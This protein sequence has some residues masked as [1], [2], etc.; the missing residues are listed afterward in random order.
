[1]IEI[2]RGMSG[3]HPASAIAELEKAA[4]PDPWSKKSIEEALEQSHYLN[5][6]AWRGEK[7]LGYLLFSHV[8]DEGEI[9][10]IAVDASVRRQ[11]IAA[12]LF[13]ELLKACRDAQIIK[14]MLDVRTGNEAAIGFYKKM[15]FETDGFRKNF[16]TNPA[17]D[18]ILMSRKIVQEDETR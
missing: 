8:L 4:F 13:A 18:A 9:V 12:L 6:C 2:S 5:L 11:G 16:Y 14:I 17:E 10:R 7:L 15:G 1:M 3:K